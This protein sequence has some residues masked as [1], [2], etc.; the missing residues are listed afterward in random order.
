ME[1]K[2]GEGG[3]G[4]DASGSSTPL[5][6]KTSMRQASGRGELL[7]EPA[8]PDPGEAISVE[9]MGPAGLPRPDLVGRPL[10]GA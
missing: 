8:A 4:V 2:L 3:L 6:R 1:A 7:M 5:R 9:V 10:A